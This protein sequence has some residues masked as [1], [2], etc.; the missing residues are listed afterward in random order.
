MATRGP[1]V[2]E[3]LDMLASTLNARI[4]NL[5]YGKQGRAAL[6]EES[7]TLYTAFCRTVE[8]GHIKRPD[9]KKA[10]ER[11][12]YLTMKQENAIRRFEKTAAEL[13]TQMRRGR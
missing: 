9:L 1:T 11:M 2:S 3:K 6:R 13:I 10:V 8:G 5:E 7:Q 12:E 4:D